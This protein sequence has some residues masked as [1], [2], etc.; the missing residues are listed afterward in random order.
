MPNDNTITP[1]TNVDVVP[2]QIPQLTDS[3]AFIRRFQEG[4]ESIAPSKNNIISPSL[5]KI[6]ID[7]SAPDVIGPFQFHLGSTYASKVGSLFDTS[8]SMLNNIGK[9]INPYYGKTMMNPTVD[10]RDTHHVLGDGVTWMPNYKTFQY[11]VDNDARLSA[12]QSQS[13]K[14]WNPVHRIVS[15]TRKGVLDLASGVYGLMGAIATMKMETLYNND[16]SN[17]IE[18]LTEQ[19]NLDYKN[20]YNE[21]ER[22]QDFGANLKTWDNFLGGAEFTTR[23][24]FGEA[25]LDTALILASPLTGGTSAVG[26]SGLIGARIAN[27]AGKA[28]RVLKLGKFAKAMDTAGD[29]ARG[30]AKATR[31][32][33]M[34]DTANDALRVKGSAISK[35]MDVM[36][37]AEYNTAKTIGMQPKNVFG[38]REHSLEALANFGKNDRFWKNFNQVRYALVS[39]T[40]E[41]GF[42]AKQA[43]LEMDQDFYDYYKKI[44]RNPTKEESD[45]FA[46]RKELAS[47]GVLMA[48]MAILAPSNMFMLGKVFG[49][50]TLLDKFSNPLDGLVKEKLLRIGIEKGRDGLKR[51][52]TRSAGNK[53]LGF[54]IPTLE[55]AGVEGV[56]E[57]GGQ[58]IASKTWQNYTKAGYNPEFA[59]ET[60]SISKAFNKAFEEQFSTQHGLEEVYI[61]ALIGAL[62]G[63]IGGTMQNR[64]EARM[65]HSIAKVENSGDAFFKA[66]K[67]D[68]YS[69]TWLRELFQHSNRFQNITGKIDEAVNNGDALGEAM[70]HKEAMVSLLQAY[71]NLGRKADFVKGLT[72]AIQGIDPEKLSE[73]TGIDISRID[74]YKKNM[75]QEMQDTADIYMT[76]YEG[77]RAWFKQNPVGASHKDGNGNKVTAEQYASKLAYSVTMADSYMNASKNAYDL[78]LRK[79]AVHNVDPEV[80]DKAGVFGALSAASNADRA[81]YAR[82]N[83]DIE[84]ANSKITSV[85]NAIT[86]L[87]QAENALKDEDS[88]NEDLSKKQQANVEKRIKLAQELSE[89]T[90]AKQR[91]EDERLQLWNN[92]QDNF[93]NNSDTKRGGSFYELDDFSKSVE[94]VEK[95]LSY[96]PTNVQTELQGILSM[97][98]QANE[99][100][101]SFSDMA[102]LMLDPS[103]KVKGYDEGNSIV[104]IG[105]I[106][107]RA[108]YKSTPDKVKQFFDKIAG[109]SEQS[110]YAKKELSKYVKG[111]LI[112]EEM[113]SDPKEQPS[114]EVK[115]Y[116]KNKINAQQPFDNEVEE[117]YY[118][119]FKKEIDDHEPSNKDN[120]SSNDDDSSK[121]DDPLNDDA[122]PTNEDKARKTALKNRIKEL[123]QLLQ[124]LNNGVLSD[125]EAKSKVDTIEKRLKEIDEQIE[126][127]LVVR[128]GLDLSESDKEQ[129]ESINSEIKKVRKELTSVNKYLGDGRFV[130]L[131]LEDIQNNFSKRIVNAYVKKLERQTE[132][133][134]ELEKFLAER[135]ALQQ[136]AE[137][138][139]F[140]QKEGIDFGLRNLTQEKQSLKQEVQDTINTLRQAIEDELNDLNEELSDINNTQSLEKK[141]KKVRKQI[142]DLEK[143]AQLHSYN[144]T[145]NN[146]DV[147]DDELTTKFDENPAIQT[148]TSQEAINK[149]NEKDVKTR[150]RGK[151]KNLS[152][153]YY[154]IIKKIVRKRRQLERLINPKAKPYE[155]LTSDDERIKWLFDNI[156]AVKVQTVEEAIKDGH[157]FHED[158][159]EYIGLLKK[160]AKQRTSEENQRF[161]ELR[162]TFL[163]SEILGYIPGLSLLDVVNKHV[164]DENN[165]ELSESASETTLPEIQETY[166][167][168]EE[169]D[170]VDLKN[171]D[172]HSAGVTLVEDIVVIG[173]HPNN[174]DNTS[175]HN[176]NAFT[177]LN[178]LFKKGYRVED[179][180]SIPKDKI[181]ANL[182][183]LR[184]DNDYTVVL[185]NDN[186]GETIRLTRTSKNGESR[187][188]NLQV[189]NDDFN[190]ITQ[191]LNLKV[192]Q[193]TSGAYGYAMLMEKQADDTYKAIQGD[194][195]KVSIVNKS[196]KKVPL[197]LDI[198][199]L[200]NLAKGDKVYIKYDPNDSYNIQHA[201][202]IEDESQR[203][204]ERVQ[205]GRFHVYT[206]DG[207]FIG[208]TKSP[209]LIEGT[210]SETSVKNLTAVL[211]SIFTNKP[212]KNGVY[213]QE[214]EVQ[215][216]YLNFPNMTLDSEGNPVQVPVDK[217]K[218][219][220][221]GYVR[222]GK[223][224]VVGDNNPLENAENVNHSYVKNLP[225][226]GIGRPVVIFKLGNMRHIFPINI[227]T[228]PRDVSEYI[229]SVDDILNSPNPIETKAN[230]INMILRS[231]GI[232]DDA[233]TDLVKNGNDIQAIYDAIRDFSLKPDLTNIDSYKEAS[234]FADLNVPFTAGKLLLKLPNVNND[235]LEILQQSADKLSKGISLDTET[236][237][238]IRKI[239]DEIAC[240][241]R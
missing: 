56:Y 99:G 76:A 189:S 35:A 73:T 177:L 223:L 213:S 130:G 79:L 126:K 218:V 48:N 181:V 167:G 43:K 94:E 164:E 109:L 136:N 225:L 63:G 207:K 87:T 81:T 238:K 19:T 57:E 51:A 38:M 221:Y 110:T 153:E 21:A 187:K 129:L 107:A 36:T 161:A 222:N 241:V 22:N 159:E 220:G 3:S 198:T 227:K 86:K 37:K 118:Q 72:S 212:T 12:L 125:T 149:D 100:F 31:A 203:A 96:L 185:K 171:H 175:F 197:K 166:K 29:I 148:L 41:A 112:T 78:F 236:K 95:A 121:S 33:R 11:G 28:G 116:L 20:Y 229:D 53:F 32:L 146:L 64:R 62:S 120:N 123:E 170:N 174:A 155:E 115:D 188:S 142:R 83:S 134:Q 180:G 27:V 102:D 55:S 226:D 186:T 82:L 143:E 93:Y 111:P 8:N 105:G 117:E 208:T 59:K 92:L 217:S 24:L 215:K 122:Q 65:Q 40:Y 216:N 85:E 70:G 9:Y 106:I 165:K 67:E 4:L 168:I 158:L 233:R 26:A 68:G 58:G 176:W 151:P 152:E 157:I 18:E 141:V 98:Q 88:K 119:R 147:K 90:Q 200:N 199:A 74:A 16:F 210:G 235:S 205:N 144:D 80:I 138:S 52:M 184:L 156:E 104:N 108:Q 132:L 50:P 202:T 1:T 13:E 154:D 103:V 127:E 182:N 124:D 25:V 71:A 160:P 84:K 209:K 30:T 10:I 47:D 114:V 97:F 60:N 128:E 135:E 150:G 219:L 232:V 214:I 239:T 34:A 2:S 228:E 193:K 179:D 113:L 133:E 140:D 240:K 190:K 163:Q 49:S 89:L 224:T 237:N 172:K 206:K 75:I 101:R 173:R 139:V 77:A 230:A 196:G 211:T 192:L 231:L 183:N 61:G 69:A 39:P 162:Q 44:G 66:L 91:L 137:K 201:E 5:P 194:A 46:R 6:H 178:K 131:S 7:T 42:E 17:Y 169:D 45:E 204:I 234:A 54:V 23:L 15:N 191:E 195:H 145:L 14:F